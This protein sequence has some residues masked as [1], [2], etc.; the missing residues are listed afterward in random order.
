MSAPCSIAHLR[1]LVNDLKRIES[2]L[3]FFIHSAE[4]HLEALDIEVGEND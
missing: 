4:Q 3:S 2:E 1:I